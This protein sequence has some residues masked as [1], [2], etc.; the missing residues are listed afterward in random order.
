[1][2]AI[3]P[4]VLKVNSFYIKQISIIEFSPLD[5]AGF[6]NVPHWGSDREGV[7]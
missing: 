5:I 3:L 6:G 1:M 7:K 4:H 2:D